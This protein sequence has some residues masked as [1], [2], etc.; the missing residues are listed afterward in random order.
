MTY[1]FP[2]DKDKAGTNVDKP[3]KRAMTFLSRV[4]YERGQI[5][6]DSETS[7]DCHQHALNHKLKCQMSFSAFF[8]F[9]P[10]SFN[11]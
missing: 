7:H 6:E 3:V 2:Q 8:S 11:S 9:I 10:S 5:K 1:L 4:E